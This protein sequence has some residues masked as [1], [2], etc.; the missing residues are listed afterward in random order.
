MGGLVI[1]I[2]WI[3]I[4]CVSVARTKNKQ[5][6]TAP[7]N[8]PQKTAPPVKSAPRTPA[9]GQVSPQNTAQRGQRTQNINAYGQNTAGNRQSTAKYS[10]MGPKHGRNTTRKNQAMNRQTAGGHGRNPSG[11]KE[12]ILTRVNRNIQ[13]QF[14][15]DVLEKEQKGISKSGTEQPQLSAEENRDLMKEVFD[16][17]I[18]GPDTSTYYG[19]DFVAE[20]VEMVNRSLKNL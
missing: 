5:E 7:N 12:D 11:Q 9:Y 3:V 8:A 17:M 18:V 14:A 10:Q 2:F 20:G 16:L 15:D 13:Q 19:R 4:I 6:T 1:I